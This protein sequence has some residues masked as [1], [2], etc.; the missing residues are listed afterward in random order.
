MR[1]LAI[2]AAVAIAAVSVLLGGTSA[3]ANSS[4]IVVPPGGGGGCLALYYAPGGTMVGVYIINTCSSPVNSFSLFNSNSGG[5]TRCIS[6]RL[7]NFF[8]TGD[9]YAITFSPYNSAV[10]C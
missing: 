2:T 5:Y 8:S 10:P 3:S 1:K 7:R 6:Y 4:S 9:R